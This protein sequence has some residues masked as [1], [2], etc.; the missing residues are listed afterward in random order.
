VT[1]AIS[2]VLSKTVFLIQNGPTF[3]EEAKAVRALPGAQRKTSV[4]FPTGPF[5]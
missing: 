2:T 3:G 4:N 5:F 1:V